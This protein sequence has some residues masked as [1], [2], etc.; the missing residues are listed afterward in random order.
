MR[1]QFYI[2]Y[3]KVDVTVRQRIDDVNL[4]QKRCRIH[5]VEYGIVSVSFL[6]VTY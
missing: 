1:C 5:G 4:S 2:G 6:A 3:E